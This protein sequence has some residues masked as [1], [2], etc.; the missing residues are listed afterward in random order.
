MKEIIKV[1][2]LMECKILNNRENQGSQGHFYINKTDKPLI[3]FNERKEKEDT[4]Y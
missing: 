3:K 1:R 4:N 2:E